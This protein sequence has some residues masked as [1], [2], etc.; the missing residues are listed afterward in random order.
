MNSE[1]SD[2]LFNFT[3][4]LRRDFMDLAAVDKLLTTTRTVRRRLDPTRPVPLEVIEECLELAIQ[5]PIGGDMPRYRFI[6]I[7]EPD[8]K[9]NVAA[10]YRKAQE[11]I[12]EPYMQRL[13]PEHGF[14]VGVRFFLDHL[15]EIP[16]LIFSCIDAITPDMP[17]WRIYSRLGSIYPIT[18]S[19]ML[20]LRS[21]GLA[22]AWTS[23]HAIYED[24]VKA[25][26]GV[27][28][29]IGLAALLPVAYFT[30]DD[31]RPAKRIPAKERTYWN[32][33]QKAR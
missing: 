7:T 22:S 11:V 9:A 16:V 25:V 24:E 2:F 19:L 4:K 6:V 1:L 3:P 20:A 18:W 26:L 8:L 21:R 12:L 15:H 31:F 13:G 5:A 30:G 23:V 10:I 28:E 14:M 32:G 27:P 33:W 17:L 29:S